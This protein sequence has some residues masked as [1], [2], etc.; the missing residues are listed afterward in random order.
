MEGVKMSYGKMTTPITFYK[1]QK[2]TDPEG[3]LIT[4]KYPLL[5]IRAYRE[6]RHGSEGWKNR[7]AYTTATTLFRIRKTPCFT[8]STDHFIVCGDE[9]FEIVSIENVKVKGMYMEILAE[10]IEPDG[11][12]HCPDAR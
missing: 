5:R 10:R 8:Y 7:A 12:M 2:D 1:R 11:K 6:D 4:E 3:F 9:Q